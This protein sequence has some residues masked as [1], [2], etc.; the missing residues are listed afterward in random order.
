MDRNLV[1]FILL[2]NSDLVTLL[3]KK[4]IKSSDFYISY[5]ILIDVVPMQWLESLP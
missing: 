4:R 5:G 1:P 2:F 3:A